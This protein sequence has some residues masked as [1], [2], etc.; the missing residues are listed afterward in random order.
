[1][2][3][4]RVGCLALVHG[5]INDVEDNGKAVTLEV[6]MG[7]IGWEVSGNVRDKL[8]DEYGVAL[9]QNKNLMPIDGEDFS[10]E[11]ERQKELING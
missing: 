7:T 5:L 2:S 9:F 6:K 10:H 8:T 3:E 1:M 4:L 11:D